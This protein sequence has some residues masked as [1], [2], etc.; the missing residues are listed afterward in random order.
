MKRKPA[1]I[2]EYLDAL[3]SG[4]RSALERLRKIIH[5]A[6]PGAEERISY[7]I[8]AFRLHGKWLVYLGAGA[9]HCAIYGL[10]E[11]RKGELKDYDTSGKG[12]IRFQPDK[13]LPATLV[14]KLLKARIAAI[15]Q[16]MGKGNRKG[17]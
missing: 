12:T 8:P 17:R 15:K 11:T 5:A 16:G 7:Q 2:D 10:R 4:K 6:A 9:N 14:R 3:T 1:T 13:P